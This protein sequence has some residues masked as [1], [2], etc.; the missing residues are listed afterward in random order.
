MKPEKILDLENDG[1]NMAVDGGHLYIRCKRAMYR[2]D[3]PGMRLAAQQTVFQKDG[4][5]RG[6]SICGEAVFLTDFCVMG[7]RILAGTVQ[8]ELIEADAETLRP[9]KK[10]QHCKKNIY[11]VVPSGGLVYTVSQDMAIR[12][13]QADT[14]E[15]ARVAKKA[16]KGMAR[17]LGVHRDALVVADSNRVTLWDRRTLAFGEAF[18]FPTGAYN[19]G[20][21]LH[22]GALYGSD[23]QGVYAMPL[24]QG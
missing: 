1:L 6:F 18:E 15:T 13:V 20:V 17:I 16:V 2:Y 14:L 8:G 19:K 23:A 5:A 10:A 7:S 12:S 24:A 3:L 21:L 9:T 22:G 11:S 4:K